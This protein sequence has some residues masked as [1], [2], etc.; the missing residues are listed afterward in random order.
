MLLNAES[1]IAEMRVNAYCV[2]RNC[3]FWRLIARIPFPRGTRR[4]GLAK[5]RWLV[6]FQSSYSILRSN[7]AMGSSSA[8][9]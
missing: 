8:V 6:A 7:E 9:T 4:Q 1:D 3:S 2:P 5:W